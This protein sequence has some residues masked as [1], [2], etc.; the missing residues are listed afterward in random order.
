MT[1]ILNVLIVLVSMSIAFSL[2]YTAWMYRLSRIGEFR[3]RWM[4]AEAVYSWRMIDVGEDVGFDRR[5]DAMNSGYLLIKPLYFTYILG[6][7]DTSNLLLR[8][9]LEIKRELLVIRDVCPDVY[10]VIHELHAGALPEFF[11]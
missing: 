4:L 5:H 9:P 11:E 1:T 8:Q 2:I 3:Q 6:R 7:V 10:D